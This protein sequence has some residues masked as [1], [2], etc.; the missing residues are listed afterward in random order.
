MDP[1]LARLASAAATKLVEALTTT[2]WEQARKAV[3]SLWR[4]VHPDRAD[5]V[6][7]EITEAREELAAARDTGDDQPGLDLVAAWRSRLRNLLAANPSLADEVRELTKQLQ[8]APSE[9]GGVSIGRVEMYADVSDQGK[10][11]QAL[12][13]QHI[14]E[15]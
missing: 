4:R 10:A 7:S 6:E 8:P 9:S 12:G 15:R 14:T 1:E 2:A 5:T 11:Y 3:G 13:D